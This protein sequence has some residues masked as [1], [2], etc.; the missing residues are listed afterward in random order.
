MKFGTENFKRLRIVMLHNPKESLKLINR[1]NYR[2]YLFDEVPDISKFCREHENYKKLLKKYGIEVLELSDFVRTNKD[3]LNKRP[4]LAFL[5]DIAVITSKG[6]I[7]SNMAFWGRKNENLVVKEALTNLKIPI[8]MEF[9]KNEFFEGFLPLSKEVALVANT[10]RY[11]ELGINEFCTRAPT[12]FE[13]IILVQVPQARRFMHADMIFGRVKEDLA[14]AYLP[15]FEH[16]E[17]ITKN[18]R[19]VVNFEEYMNKKGIELINISS[20]EQKNWGCSFVPL[21]PGIIF[22]YDIALNKKTK[23]K[24]KEK[25]VKIIE[26]SPK[27]LLAGGGSLRCLTCQIL[28]E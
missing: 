23:L 18:K 17:I 9:E 10:E 1:K 27:A 20:E 3:L 24:L 2:K 19:F 8:F 6:A 14:I 22:H 15:A 7:L 5:H 4:N 26:F 11:N 16:V 13:E 12:L 21:E 28:R 25:G